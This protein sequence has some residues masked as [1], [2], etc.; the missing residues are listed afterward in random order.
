[1]Q[2]FS[3]IGQKIEIKTKAIGIEQ[4]IEISIYSKWVHLFKTCFGLWTDQ[5]MGLCLVN[6][7]NVV[8]NF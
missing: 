5:D 2:M 3:Q 7:E 6:C 4:N 1:M 8:V